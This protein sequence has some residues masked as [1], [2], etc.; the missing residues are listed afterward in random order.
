VPPSEFGSWPGGV[1]A[2]VHL[3]EDDE[4][5]AEDLEAARAF[6]AAELFLYPGATH[7]FTDRS[8]PDHDER[9]AALVLERVLAF[10]AG[11]G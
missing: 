6:D 11:H 5:G 7:L 8:L 3:M 4:V 9:A 1:P 2:Q 10:L